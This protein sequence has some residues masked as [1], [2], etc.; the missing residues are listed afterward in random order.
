[1]TSLW[2]SFLLYVVSEKSQRMQLKY[3][4]ATV[5]G[6]VATGSLV[7]I[8]SYSATFLFLIANGGIMLGLLSN[9]L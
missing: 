2:V 1:M 4:G 5:F 8:A 9:V 7:S 6:I 3:H